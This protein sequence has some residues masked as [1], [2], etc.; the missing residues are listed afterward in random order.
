MGIMPP[1]GSFF[2]ASPKEL[3]KGLDSGKI[4]DRG[5]L[6]KSGRGLMKHGYREGSA[7]PKPVGNVEQINEHGQ[8]ILES[9]L[10]HPEKK[11]SKYTHKRFGEII[12]VVVPGKGGVRFT[13]DWEMIHFMEP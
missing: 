1:P 9:I 4:L 13:N 3:K 6:T 5:G 12:E 11:I 7:Y 2:K 8:K 10:N